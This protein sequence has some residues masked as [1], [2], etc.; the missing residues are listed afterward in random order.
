MIELGA[1]NKKLI[2]KELFG[3]GFLGPTGM[4]VLEI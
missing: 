1:D 2:T 4:V 3:L